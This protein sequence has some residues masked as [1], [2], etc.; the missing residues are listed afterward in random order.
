[1]A[2]FVLYWALCKTLCSSAESVGF[3][4]TQQRGIFSLQGKVASMNPLKNCRFP[5][6]SRLK[7][8]SK[9]IIISSVIA[10]TIGI[11]S[12]VGFETSIKK[13][14]DLL[15][16]QT[17]TSLQLLAGQ[18]S[19]E[20]NE[21]DT[22]SAHVATNLTLQRELNLLM[23][24]T[25]AVARYGA[26]DRVTRLLNNYIDSRIICISIVMPDGTRVSVG[27][28]SSAE[29]EEV[30]AQIEDNTR[31]RKGGAYW[32][33][34]RRPDSSILCARMI[35][36]IQ[37]LSLAPLGNLVIRVDMSKMVHAVTAVVSDDTEKFEILISNAQEL[38]YPYREEGQTLPE[39]QFPSQENSGYSIEKTD[40]GPF[41]TT[42]TGLKD[43]MGWKVSLGVRYDEVFY[44][45]RFIRNLFIQIVIA[46]IL[47]SVILSRIMIKSVT[48]HFND[49]VQKMNRLKSGNFELLS[50]SSPYGEDELS[51]LNQY[52]DDMT[53]EFKKMIRENYEKEVLLSQTQL[54]FLEQQINPH[55]L[56]NTLDSINWLAKKNRQAQISVMVESLG[57]LL[58]ASLNQDNDLIPI[59]EELAILES[60]VAIQR[61]RFA[62]SLSVQFDVQ[63]TTLPAMIPKLVL[64]PL[65]E[66]AI[67]HSR[68]DSDDPCEIRVRIRRKGDLVDVC[69]E[70]NGPE[71]DVD[72]LSKIRNG[73]VVPRG[74]GIGLINIDTRLCLIF[75]DAHGLSFANRNGTV[76]VRFSIP[77]LTESPKR[78]VS[79]SCIK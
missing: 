48:L 73:S 11:V 29:S 16:E 12:I 50:P 35:R 9:I 68:E 20:L 24:E 59:R 28:D 66:N 22:L 75:G 49:L 26:I 33:S 14:N 67:T 70:N 10:L 44:S 27:R 37:G 7:L 63:E 19:T 40:Q 30:S 6:F 51:L 38:L 60:Y 45:I 65:V 61:F 17:S 2:R 13:H 58:R 15:Y 64:Q 79:E 31:L 41:F 77:F 52:F 54:K 32:C 43:F 57:N 56:F 8:Y 71:I 3:R 47:I 53:L 5:F 76:C 74:N 25:D 36:Q 34:A 39:G 23:S 1:M 78:S 18:I 69:V 46:S 4:R 55:F 62:D 42:S 21:L 72:I